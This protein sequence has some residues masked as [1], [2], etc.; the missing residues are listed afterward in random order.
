MREKVPMRQTLLKVEGLKTHFRTAD[1]V[2]KAVDGL[3]L[4]I[5][6]GET[7]TIVGESGSG[8]SVTGL[9][10][11]RLVEGRVIFD[12]RDLMALNPSEMRKIRGDRISMVF[13]HPVESLDP[14]R[15][16]G[17]QLRQAILVHEKCAT[18]EVRR[19]S[20]EALEHAGLSPETM[21]K[22]PFELSAGTCQ[23]VMIAI[24]LV[25]KPDLL[26][27][28]EPTTNLDMEAEAEILAVLKRLQKE[29]EIAILLITHDFAV[30]SAMSD[31]VVVMYAGHVMETG[32]AASLL[33]R[34][35]HPYTRGLLNS[36]PKIGHSR[37]FLEQIPGL[38]A[39]LL[40]LPPGCPFEPR[41]GYTVEACRGRLPDLVDLGEGRSVRCI[42]R[43]NLDELEGARRAP[44]LVTDGL[45][46]GIN[47]AN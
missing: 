32:P 10:I 31:R 37:G 22:Y 43:G 28:D 39:N 8:K 11:M 20:V 27:T 24:A 41:C 42:H 13:Q 18:E 25:N 9:S 40:A 3:S 33:E 35:R 23:K 36:V 46:A 34:P 4:E 29:F 12:G 16:A 2:V 26:I 30:V 21:D 38:P 47:H 17:E 5:H 7:V 14:A 19:R 45:K 44:Q 6:R 1:G 15:T